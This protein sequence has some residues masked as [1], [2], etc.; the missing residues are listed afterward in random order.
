MAE[1][2]NEIRVPLEGDVRGLETPTMRLRRA[3]LGWGARNPLGAVGVVIVLAVGVLGL[4]GPMLVP[5]DPQSSQALPL[6]GPSSDHLL[7][8]DRFGRDVLARVVTGARIS[9]V[10]AMA[11][12]ALAVVIALSLGVVGGWYGRY[13][14]TAIQRVVD[15]VMAFPS[16]ILLML[17]VTV[18]GPSITNLIALLSFLYGV[19]YS[20]VIRSSVLTL[21]SREFVLAARTIGASESRIMLRHIAPNTFGPAMV[22]AST[23]WGVAIL[24]EAALSFLGLGVPPPTPSW[25][26]MIKDGR[27]L[28]VAAPWIVLSPAIA[29][30]LTVFGFNMLGDALRDTLDPR[31]RGTR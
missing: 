17:A 14:D 16:L 22:I 24:S 4:L 28:M 12:S 13:V 3:V 6:G 9:A 15:G 18:F 20:R 2:S 21:K 31:L 1:V 23:V 27:P 25:G 7:G 29:L 5:H 8:T 30:G 26:G 11:T 19:R 10:I